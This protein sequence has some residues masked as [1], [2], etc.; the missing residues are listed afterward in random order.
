MLDLPSLPDYY[1]Q[2]YGVQKFA[3]VTGSSES[4][5]E[6]WRT[7]ARNEFP[8][9]ALQKLL[10]FDPEP[11]GE[12]RPLY[13][14]PN[15]DV[16][17]AVIL[18]TNR[19]PEP[20]TIES[21]IKMYDSRSMVFKRFA[22]NSLFH[23]RNMAAAWFL[24]TNIPWSYWS[25]DDAVHPCG[26]SDW[27]KTVA[28][29]PDMPSVYA[30]MNSISRLLS[31]GKKLIG[32]SYVSRSGTAEPQFSGGQSLEV[33]EQMRAGPRNLVLKR[34]W[35]GFGGVL[36]HR[37]VFLDIIKTQGKEIQVTN[38]SIRR[39]LKY[40]YSFFRPIEDDVGDDISFCARAR[41]AGHE[42]FVDLAISAG[43][44]GSQVYTY[45]NIRKK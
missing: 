45:R 13:D 14:S 39:R 9:T 29:V 21:I 8:L 19:K 15:P 34:D 18:P 3:E 44:V 40:D 24:G 12:V 4:L 37:D 27:F 5:V 31:S 16:K 32:E 33:S 26:D 2:K 7:R 30:G 23:V 20:E 25:D 10:E 36:V 1:L 11:L 38:E 6:F 22:F 17:V 35:V 43:H 41:K 28:Q 42:V